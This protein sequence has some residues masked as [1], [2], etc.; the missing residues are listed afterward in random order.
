MKPLVLLRPEPGLSH[1]AK[2]ARALG[3]T[4]IECPLFEVRPLA[5]AA[6]PAGEFDALMLTSVNAVRH[7]GSGLTK[8]RELPVLAVGEATA[9]AARDAGFQV[10]LVGAGGVADLLSNV[11]LERRL[12][13]LGGAEVQHG[14]RAMTR[15][16]VYASV[17]VDDVTLP[18]LNG[19]VIAVHSPRAGQRLAELAH[20][21]GGATVAAISAAAGIACGLGWAYSEVAPRPHD[22]SLLALAARLCQVGGRA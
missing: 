19:A 3:L 10:E 17:V 13:H 14:G 9:E 5:W 20:D 16:A 21:R 15:A 6:P 22:S 8:Y 11:A 2:G 7:G 1:S 4:V 12:L 18:A